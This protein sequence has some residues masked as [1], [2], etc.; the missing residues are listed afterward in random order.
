MSA[1]ITPSA[2]ANRQR[3]R[4]EKSIPIVAQKLAEHIVSELEPEFSDHYAKGYVD[5]FE[6]FI[7]GEPD[8]F[9]ALHGKD[10][11]IKWF[12]KHG[13]PIHYIMDVC[14]ACN[15]IV[16]QLLKDRYD[17][18]AQVVV[19]NSGGGEFFLDKYECLIERPRLKKRPFWRFWRR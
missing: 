18:V 13:I 7:L 8:E 3:A 14:R 15:P 1:N 5:T 6:N 4:V 9:G 17:I 12:D 16:K 10:I 2:A 19:R 11:T